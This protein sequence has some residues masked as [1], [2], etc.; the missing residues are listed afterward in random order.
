MNF[1]L[2]KNDRVFYKREHYLDYV[3]LS[4]SIHTTIVN[5]IKGNF[6]ELQN[7]DVVCV[8]SDEDGKFHGSKNITYKM[9]RKNE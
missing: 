2:K 1:I 9:C 8:T 7:G 3:K 4:Y 6:A 5:D